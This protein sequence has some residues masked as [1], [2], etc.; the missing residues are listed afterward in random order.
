MAI[1]VTPH[2]EQEEKV[3]R[4]FLDSLKYDYLEEEN[5]CIPP[6]PGVKRQTLEEYNQEID[7]AVAEIEAGNYLT[8]EQ[9]LKEFENKTWRKK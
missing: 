3:L 5:I 9:V 1:L 4:A 2:N 7:N 6:P 8:H